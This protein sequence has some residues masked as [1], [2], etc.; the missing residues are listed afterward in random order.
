VRAAIGQRSEHASASRRMP[1]ALPGAMPGIFNRVER[2]SVNQLSR[3]P[4]NLH[5]NDRHGQHNRNVNYDVQRT[6]RPTGSVNPNVLHIGPA[7]RRI[8]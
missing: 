5:W 7:G 3:G 8:G 6:A 2:R 4:I 1:L